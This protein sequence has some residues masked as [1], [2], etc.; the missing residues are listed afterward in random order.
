VQPL[1][2]G[3]VGYVAGDFLK[4]AVSPD[5]SVATGPDDSAERAGRG[6]FDASG[7]V[8]CAQEAGQ[9]MMSCEFG[10]ARAG[11]GYATVVITKP[12]GGTRAIF[13]RMGRAIGADTSEADNPGEFSA[14]REED[15]TIIRIGD[16]HYEIPDAV[17]LGG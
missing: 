3:P 17:V 6:D 5:G 15:L 7:K 2:G 13:F 9:A 14:T 1:G 8:G 11:G 12:D 16:E 10:V 4:P